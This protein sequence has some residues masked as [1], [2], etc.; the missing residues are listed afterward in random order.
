TAAQ[1]SAVKAHGTG[2]TANDVTELN[3]LNLTF[4]AKVP[5]FS[6]L[7]STFGH[8]LG[9]SA[10]LEL[11]T[12]TWCAEDGFIPGTPGFGQRAPESMLT[13][14]LEPSALSSGPT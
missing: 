2:T 6:S 13:P 5:P 3:A 9:A 14:A 10:A 8:T 4:G 11:V 7:K 1:V 12:W